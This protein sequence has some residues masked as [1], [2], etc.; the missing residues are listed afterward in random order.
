MPLTIRQ[1]GINPPPGELRPHHSAPV[2][3][4]RPVRREQA[5]EEHRLRRKG[6]ELGP[7]VVI[8]AGGKDSLDVGGLDG[9][10]AL[11][12]VCEGRNNGVRLPVAAVDAAEVT[13]KKVPAEGRF[14]DFIFAVEAPGQGEWICGKGDGLAGV[15][16]GK[17]VEA[18]FLEEDTNEAMEIVEGG[19]D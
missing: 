1:I 10:D 16:A 6:A 3:P 2:R 4:H 14:V 15:G 7:L 12:G 5:G 8:E 17:G 18:T 19:Q 9:V 13:L 11:L